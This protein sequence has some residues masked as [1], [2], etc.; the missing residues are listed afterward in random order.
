MFDSR[1]LETAIGIVFVFLAFSLITTAIQEFIASAIKLRATTLQS[2]LKEMLTDGGKGLDFY[3]QV[4]SHPLIT[5]AGDKP[6]YIS[7]AQF[8]NTVI[9]VLSGAQGVPADIDAL[10]IAVGNMPE[11]PYKTALMSLFRDGDTDLKGF[12]TRLQNWFDHAMDRVT[13][14]YKRISQYISLALGGILAFVFQVNAIAIG[15]QLWNEVPLQDA[16][17]KC[18]AAHPSPDSV[19]K[20]LMAFHFEPLWMSPPT[21][22]AN[23]FFW[24]VGCAIT[25]M[26]IT[27]GAPFWFDL[28]QSFISLRGTG[29]EPKKA[30]SSA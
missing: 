4:V 18:C 13:G 23:L 2:G 11:A 22:D 3:E 15:F 1:V 10:R 5:T 25:T 28:L 26:A 30:A 12:E 21:V 16:V 6:S 17:G 19:A 27:L 7:S 29:P 24:F 14:I 8:S 20:M 9:H